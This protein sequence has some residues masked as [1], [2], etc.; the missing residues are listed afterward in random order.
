MGNGRRGSSIGT[1]EQMDRG[2]GVLL[3]TV[4]VVVL[5]VLGADTASRVAVVLLCACVEGGMKRFRR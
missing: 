4:D 3:S 5:H 2:R 1:S